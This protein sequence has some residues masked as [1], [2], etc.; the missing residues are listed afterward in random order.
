MSTVTLNLIKI[1][2]PPISDSGFRSNNYDSKSIELPKESEVVELHTALNLTNLSM[3]ESD[4]PYI[5]DLSDEQNGNIDKDTSNDASGGKVIRNQRSFRSHSIHIFIGLTEQF[6]QCSNREDQISEAYKRD[7]VLV[8]HQKI[9]V[10]RR[11]AKI[12]QQLL[13]KLTT[14]L[15]CMKN[16]N[17]FHYN[18]AVSNNISNVNAM[19][20]NIIIDPADECSRR[21]RMFR[22][23]S[24]SLALR[25]SINISGNLLEIQPI[26]RISSQNGM[27]RHGGSHARGLSTDQKL[28]LIS[29]YIM[30][31]YL[32][33]NIWRFIP[34][35]Y[36]AIYGFGEDGT[37]PP[38][39]EGI[40]DISHIMISC[41]SAFNFLPYLWLKSR[42]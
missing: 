14:C 2:F 21:R 7:S 8:T 4:I 34:N 5:D 29:I 26:R 33:S 20:A 17:D 16:D 35:C 12:S 18:Q 11:L 37:W 28:S 13:Q 1:N 27:V 3:S 36:D 30:V 39:L 32:L 19:L 41:N 42:H 9:P 23:A 6:N 15:K 24:N 22:A 25:N 31:M 38:W 40:K 10:W